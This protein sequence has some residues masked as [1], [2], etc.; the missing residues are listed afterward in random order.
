MLKLKSDSIEFVICPSCGSSG[1]IED[2]PAL[3]KQVCAECGHESEKIRLKIIAEE[4]EISDTCPFCGK[5]GDADDTLFEEDD[6]LVFKCKKCG[7]L[8]GYKF[9]DFPEFD[10]GFEGTYDSLS[11]EIAKKEGKHVHPASKYREFEKALRKREN[12]PIEKS[13][14]QLDYLIYSISQELSAAG[15]DRK[16]INR[17]NCKVC[18]FIERKGPQTNKKLRSLFPAA[19]LSIPGHRVTERQLEK[20]LGVT[21][22]T[23]RKWKQILQKEPQKLS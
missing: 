9:S 4:M 18:L 21:R 16:V 1:Y 7:K 12:D 23:I 17:A 14:K 15:I 22:K 2:Y 13:K 11:I 6:I 10:C 5:E 8:D 19:L 20:I 3:G